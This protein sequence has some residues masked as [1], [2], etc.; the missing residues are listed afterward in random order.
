MAVKLFE[1]KK[2]SS[3]IAA[4]IAE[5]ERVQFLLLLAQYD[6]N[7]IDYDADELDTDLSNA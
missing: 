4:Q 5:M 3:G 7:M 1:M 2:I 6:V